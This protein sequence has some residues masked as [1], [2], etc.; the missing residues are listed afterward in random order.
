MIERNGKR[1]LEQQLLT[2]ASQDNSTTFTLLPKS[3]DYYHLNSLTHSQLNMP[4]FYYHFQ[5]M[6]IG[7]RLAKV[8]GV[9]MTKSDWEFYNS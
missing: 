9:K 3:K 6:I 7:L 1:G 2:P 8:M 4:P 5:G